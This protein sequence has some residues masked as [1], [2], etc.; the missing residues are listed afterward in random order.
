L[1][2]EIRDMTQE[3]DKSTHKLIAADPQAFVDFALPGAKL[4]CI[5]RRPERLVSWEWELIMDALLEVRLPKGKRILLHH[6]FETY[7]SSKMP[8][9]LLKYSL[10]A[11]EEYHLPVVSCAWHLF[12]DARIKRSPLLWKLPRELQF[13]GE[14]GHILRFDYRVIEMSDY[15]PHDIWAKQRA[16]LVPFLPLTRGGANRD[17]V[18]EMLQHLEGKDKQDL[19]EIGFV[20]AWMKFARSNPEEH[21]WL[22]GRYRPMLELLRQEPLYSEIFREGAQEGVQEGVQQTVISMVAARFAELEPLVRRKVTA[23]NSL[24]R[25]QQLVV[26]LSR[27]FSQEE[28]ERILLSLGENA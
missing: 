20:L 11:R 2:G 25:L 19:R 23:I 27:A 5:R 15:T 24:E 16:A 17:V 7:Y 1:K 22:K 18:Q 12:N 6:E 10:A 28:T 13:L 4:E 14:K 8:G 9:R 3:W 26:E 21:D